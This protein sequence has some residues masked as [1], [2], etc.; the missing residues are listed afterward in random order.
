MQIRDIADYSQQMFQELGPRA[1]A[2]A[3]ER[4]RKCEAEG[5]NDG[6]VTWRRRGNGWEQRQ[7]GGRTGHGI[8]YDAQQL[9][10]DVREMVRQAK[11]RSVTEQGS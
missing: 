8:V 2:V 10:E 4:A 1:I 3:A 5:D 6:A 9:L 7:P 11:E